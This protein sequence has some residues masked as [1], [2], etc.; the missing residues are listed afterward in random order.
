MQSLLP[1]QR[2]N[3][4]AYVAAFVSYLLLVGQVAPLYAAAG[5][6]ATPSRTS[7]AGL[8]APAAPPSNAVPRPASLP[9]AAPNI[10]ATKVDA[11][12]DTATPDG[13]AEPGQT[14][15]YTVTIS[16]T[17]N[18]DATGVQFTDSVDP[19]TSLV[20]SSIQT[21]PIAAP[22]TYNVIGNVRIQPDAAAGLLANDC[23][24]DDTTPPCNTNLTASGPTSGPS[25]GQATVN[26]DGSFSYN[27]NPGFAGT[28][29]FTCTVRDTGPDNI[30]GNADDQTDTETVTLNVGNGTSTPGT[31]VIWFVDPSAAPGGDGRLTSPFNCYTG[32]SASCF[33]Q[34]A[35]ADPGDTIF[36]YSGAH[37][38]GYALLNNQKLV[39]AGAS[40]TLASIAGATVQSYSD[41]LP[42]TGGASPTI[43]TTAGRVRQPATLP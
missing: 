2:P 43:T 17:G 37:T 22:D 38:G 14:I 39:G 40:A 28:D 33:S 34:T 10:V 23:D 31:N 29:T 15:T 25:N 1:S 13:K 21:Q 32:A 4:R 36:L 19:H 3:A 8:S 5:R 41:A 9:F 24:P 35:A 12:D 18:A 20:A 30:A 6:P 11:W 42:S 26:A 16:N 27:P 7:D